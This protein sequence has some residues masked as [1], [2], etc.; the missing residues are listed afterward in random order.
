MEIIV[1]VYWASPVCCAL[2]WTFYRY[3]YIILKSTNEAIIIISVLSV[4][5]LRLRAIKKPI[6]EG[7]WTL[8]TVSFLISK[9]CLYLPIKY[10]SHWIF[11]H[12]EKNSAFIDISALMDVY[13][14]VTTWFQAHHTEPWTSR[15]F[16]LLFNSL[17]TSILLHLPCHTLGI[18]WTVNKWW[19]NIT[20]Y[21]KFFNQ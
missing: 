19:I 14:Y 11:L 17:Y 9:Y 20:L 3:S 16:Y 10:Q 18:C 15:P 2:G 6:Q 5:K 7:I 4:Q 8:D 12:N 13:S 1:T 21:I